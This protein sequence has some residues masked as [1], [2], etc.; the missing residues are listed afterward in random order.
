[1]VEVFCG[2]ASRSLEWMVVGNCIITGCT[3]MVGKLNLKKE[4][5]KGLNPTYSL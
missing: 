5:K 2:D 4:K 3:R 1:M